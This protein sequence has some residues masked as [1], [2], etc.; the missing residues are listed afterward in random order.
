MSKESQYEIMPLNSNEKVTVAINTSVYRPVIDCGDFVLMS[1]ISPHKLVS[2]WSSIGQPVI[3]IWE[4]DDDGV[5]RPKLDI[6]L[7]TDGTISIEK[8]TKKGT[9]R[10]DVRIVY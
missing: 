3:L 7:M 4:K 10:T 9:R 6:N 8:E 5:Y 2:L 1:D